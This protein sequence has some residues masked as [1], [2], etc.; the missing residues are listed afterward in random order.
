[1]KKFSP[2]YKQTVTGKIQQWVISVDRNTVITE[3]GQVDGKKQTTTDVIKAGKNIGRS[4]ATT[5]ETQAEAQA[6]QTFD[7]K[8]KDGYVENITQARGTKNTLQAVEPMLAHT[9][10]QK[11]KYVV[12][13]ALA[14]PKLD[15]LRCIAIIKNGKA[16]LFSRSQKE[17]LTV[18]HIVAELERLY[19]NTDITLDGELYNHEFRNSFNTIIHLAKRD[20]VHADHTKIEYHIYDVVS[21]GSHAKR[22]AVVRF[23]NT[24]CKRVDTVVVTSRAELETFQAQCIEQGYEGCMYRHP[25]GEYEHKRSNTLL[26]VKT[27]QDDEFQI[28]GAEEGTGKLMGCIGAF[29]LITHKGV[30]FKAKPACT[31]EQSKEYWRTRN[32][33]IHKKEAT[34]KFQ[35][36][37]PDGVP[38]FPVFKCVRDPE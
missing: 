19:Q 8:L 29:V 14:Q 21:P 27:F 17:Y 20:G 25:T 4:N 3:Y 7:G 6:Q 31:L 15:G 18:P 12:F 30:V 36:Y 28:I 9:I 23:P 1:M 35:N 38:R 13:P 22:M 2:L 10:E 32:N 33:Y 16:R 5:A 34:V 11:E 26:K 37:T 24:Y